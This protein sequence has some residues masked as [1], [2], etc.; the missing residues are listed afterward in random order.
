[1][2]LNN[3]QS[4]HAHTHHSVAQQCIYICKIDQPILWR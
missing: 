4:I 2:T 1:M 3:K